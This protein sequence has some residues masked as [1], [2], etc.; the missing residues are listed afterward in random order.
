M[1]NPATPF[2]RWFVAGFLATSAPKKQSSRSHRKADP[3]E[4][5]GARAPFLYRTSGRARLDTRNDVKCA[6]NGSLELCHVDAFSE[7]LHQD[8]RRML[9]RGLALAGSEYV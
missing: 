2:A 3:Y 5:D 9:A 7:R 4:D 1:R 6:R 8:T